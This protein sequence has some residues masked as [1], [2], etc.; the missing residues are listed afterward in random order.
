MRDLPEITKE[1]LKERVL[2]SLFGPVAK[3]ARTFRVP[4]GDLKNLLEMAHF[5]ELKNEALTLNESASV[6][7]VSRRKA[8][9]LSKALKENFFR[10]ER[11]HGLTRRIEY[12]LWAGAMTQG[13][14]IQTLSDYEEADIQDA[15]GRLVEQERVHRIEGRT[16]T[17]EVP[18]GE[19]R[20]Y[21]DNWLAR[22]DG[23]NNLLGNVVNAVMGRFFFDEKDAFARTLNLRIRP[24]DL[25]RLKQL[26][27]E[28]IWETLKEFD[29]NAKGAPEAQSIDLSILWAPGDIEH[30]GQQNE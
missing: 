29:E 10:P 4:L 13:R 27:E 25:P 14:I 7:G 8:A 15:L 11:E 23:L 2:Y 24:Q 6:L 30:K 5:H 26:Y 3:M 22:I 12:M 9:Q 1:E 17:Y 16:V 20:L 19:F 28:V 21:Q 18:R